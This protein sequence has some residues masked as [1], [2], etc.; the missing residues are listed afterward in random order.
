MA[1]IGVLAGGAIAYFIPESFIEYYMGSG[2]EIHAIMLA[3]GIPMYVCTSASIDSR[4]AVMKGSRRA[5]LSFFWPVRDCAA[6]IA[7]IGGQLG[8]SPRCIPLL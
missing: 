2:H 4:R 8:K 6:G 7:L 5:A 1:I 3:V